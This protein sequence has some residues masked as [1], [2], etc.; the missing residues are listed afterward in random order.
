M[1]LIHLCCLNRDELKAQLEF[2]TSNMENA[3]LSLEQYSTEQQR[4]TIELEEAQ[5]II[6]QLTTERNDLQAKI[7]YN[8]SGN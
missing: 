4:L 3:Q 8:V 6:T 2:I 1:L 5:R 7:Q